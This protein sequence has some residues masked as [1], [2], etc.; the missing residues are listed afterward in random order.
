[1]R[2][3]RRLLTIESVLA[4][5][6][7]GLVACLV[8]AGRPFDLGDEGYAYLLARL[9]ARGEL[10]YRSF[11][12]IY[13]PGEFLWLGTWLRLFGDH[14]LV[15][16][17]A[18][19]ALVGL[20]GA[21]FWRP[22]RQRSGRSV[23]AGALAAVAAISLTSGA[24]KTL[25]M[26]AVAASAA[27][28]LA[29]PAPPRPTSSGG[30]T[31]L[32]TPFAAGLLVG[33]REDSAALLCALAGLAWLRGQRSAGRAASGFAAFALGWALWWP[34]FG[35]HGELAPYLDHVVWRGLFLVRRLADPTEVGWS[36]PRALPRSTAELYFAALPLLVA[37]PLLL[38]L[39]LLVIA[40]LR[41]GQA[42]ARRLATAGAFGLAYVLQFAWE[43]P[44]TT[45]FRFHAPALIAAVAMA[46][47]ALPRRWRK[48]LALVLA[49]PL[50][51]AAT[52]RLRGE[53]QRRTLLYPCCAGL[54]A[55]IRL[56]EIPPW[57]GQLDREGGTLVVLGWSPGY[58]LLEGEGPGSRFL[59][60]FPRHLD[61][62]KVD[63]LAD[64]LLARDNR[65][66]MTTG[67]ALPPRIAAILDLEYVRAS[68]SAVVVLFRRRAP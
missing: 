1:M 7:T 48:G 44:D 43:R 22:L 57:A 49:L 68:Q 64:D 4:G 34:F 40:R 54:R 30:S 58:Y 41:S 11:D 56:M 15:L 31:W 25:A 28:V 60:T 52:E 33:W 13:P 32:L 46:A 27:A 10:L 12:P 9:V 2:R 47:F 65:W 37:L 62:A 36:P 19:A 26:A 6:G 3:A 17:A 55:G 59:S 24:F 42:G 45:H 5:L 67:Y 66:V 18:A 51:L 8:A 53:P 61:A 35:W 20:A 21:L 29:R 50:A 23:A 16:R 63:E 14:L 39:A 38:Y